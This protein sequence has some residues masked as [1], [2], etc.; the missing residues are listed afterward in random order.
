[1]AHVLHVCLHPEPFQITLGTCT[2]GFGALLPQ[3]QARHLLAFFL[4][5]ICLLFLKNIHYM[6]DGNYC[7]KF[8][9]MITLNMTVR[10]FYLSVRFERCKGI[11]CCE[12]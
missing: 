10:M 9:F 2:Q 8:R 12:V 7:L 4:L 5:C 1:M 6:L 3:R 11:P